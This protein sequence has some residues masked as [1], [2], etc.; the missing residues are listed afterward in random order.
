MHT[1]Q[2]GYLLSY[3]SWFQDVGYIYYTTL[4]LVLREKESFKQSVEGQILLAL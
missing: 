3:F 2:H 4:D 1:Q